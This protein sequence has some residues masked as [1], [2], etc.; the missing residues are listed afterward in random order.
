MK[1]NKSIL[2]LV[3]FCTLYITRVS[4]QDDSVPTKELVTLR[5]FNDNNG[6][7]YL[8]LQNSVK[9]GKEISP[10]SA[11][12]FELFLDSITGTNQIGKVITDKNGRAK[13][14][15]PP[16]LKSQWDGNYSHTFIVVRPGEEDAVTELPITKAKMQID[17]V[18]EDSTRKIIVQVNKLESG[19]WLPANEVEMKI[20]IQRLG[21]VLTAGDEETYTTDSTGTIS[22]E[23]SKKNIPGDISGN[24]VLVA[25]TEDNELYGNLSV[26]K[27]V[28]WGVAANHDTGFF[29]RR[30]LWST[31]LKAPYWLLIMACSIIMAVWGTIIYLLFQIARIKK[32]GTT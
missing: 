27:V 5:Y 26:E 23:L 28:P 2:L 14:V 25:R 20:G 12:T 31:G 13:S 22:I 29:D 10:V 21:G 18:S 1:N 16:L 6:A 9:K 4:A 32:M 3:L 15:I 11:K 17:T 19:A 7:Q 8:V 30:T 24:I